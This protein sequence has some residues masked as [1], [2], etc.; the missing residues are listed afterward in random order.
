MAK[1][2]NLARMTTATTGTGTIT[3]GAAVS[4]YLSFAGAGVANGD[5]V[6]YAIKDGNNSEIG[7]GTYTSS[8]TALTRNVSKST[9][10]NAAIN[11]SGTAEVFITPRAEDLLAFDSV[12]T[13]T[14][15]QRAQGRS[16]L[17]IADEVGAISFHTATAAPAGK[18]KAN[19]ALVSRITYVDLWTY[20]QASGNL[21]ASDS[22]WTTNSSFGMFSPGDGSTTFRIPYINGY[23]VR[24]WDDSRGTDTGRTIGSS[25]ADDLKS[26][27]HQTLLAG[28]VQILTNGIGQ[29]AGG[30]GIGGVD[31]QPKR[32]GFT[33]GTETR[34]KN[35][36]LLACITYRA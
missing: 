5:V 23:F 1:L 21:A 20:A 26:H 28:T 8:G 14:A 29:I 22:A 3:L 35:I 24:A 17:G 16:N 31:G 4:G 13:L 32:T 30:G 27:D 19:G 12:M 34:P 36:A 15:T 18:L 10:S 6:S 11:L 33:G 2:Y 9:N 25:Q 7:T